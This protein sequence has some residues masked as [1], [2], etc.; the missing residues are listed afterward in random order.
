MGYEWKTIVDVILEQVKILVIGE[1][2]F[3]ESVTRSIR[4]WDETARV[5]LT[6]QE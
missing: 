1:L 4:S 2:S 3:S 5:E 6:L